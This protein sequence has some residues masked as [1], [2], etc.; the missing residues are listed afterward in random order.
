VRKVDT[1]LAVWIK[2]QEPGED[3]KKKVKLLK[4]LRGELEGEDSFSIETAEDFEFISKLLVHANRELKDLKKQKEAVTKPINQ[5]LRSFRSW[6]E[7]PIKGWEQIIRLVKRKL[8][9]YEERLI[10]EKELAAQTLA[11]AVQEDNFELAHAVSHKLSEE[12]PSVQGV[13]SR[14]VW[15]VD[16]D[17]V[18]LSKVPVAFLALDMG[19]VSV[20]LKQWQKDRERPPDLPGLPFK[21]EVR[22]SA[23]S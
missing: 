11:E 5:A 3:L 14:E 8:G 17:N 2:N 12:V 6:W 18:D 20:Y 4:Q 16:E 21:L 9:E 22:V 1:D 15:V 13:S 23:R 10:Q 19:A 7:P